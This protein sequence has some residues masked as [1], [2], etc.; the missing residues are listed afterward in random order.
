MTP[1]SPQGSKRSR[2][3]ASVLAGILVAGAGWTLAERTREQAAQQVQTVE[4]A[5][6]QLGQALLARDMASV[7]QQAQRL[8]ELPLL[9]EFFDL[10]TTQP[11]SAD[12]PELA[13]YL[14]DVLAATLQEMGD[15]SLLAVSPD[16]KVLLKEPLETSDQ[17]PPHPAAKGVYLH[18]SGDGSSELWWRQPVPAYQ[19]PDKSGGSLYL[20]FAADSLAHF[21][22]AGLVLEISGNDTNAPTISEQT[23]MG[24][25]TAEPAGQSPRLVVA[26]VAPALNILPL[27]VFAIITGFV[28]FAA[29]VWVGGLAGQ[30]RQA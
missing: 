7:E 11:V 22:R 2:L 21:E 16:G 24:S 17:V 13:A 30:G 1:P 29:S 18:R 8:A 25:A 6:I 12:V 4:T 28:V 14:Q 5:R 19:D 27:R 26:N 3:I 20:K 15:G 9:S 10:A 23:S